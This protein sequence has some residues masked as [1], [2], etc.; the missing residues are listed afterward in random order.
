MDEQTTILSKILEGS[1]G[2]GWFVILALWG[3]TANYLGKL[4][5]GKIIAFSFAELIGEWTI[6]GFTGL[7]TAYVCIGQEM[8]WHT[9]AALT[10]IAGHMGG[11]LI[12]VF[13]SH[14]NHWIQRHLN[15][16]PSE[17]AGTENNDDTN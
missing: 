14:F 12:S 8:S 3:G 10:G 9:T 11:K 2:Y 7:I 13:E 15:V 4:R 5:Q 1:L 17:P 6:S 16:K